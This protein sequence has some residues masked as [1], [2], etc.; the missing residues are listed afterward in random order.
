MQWLH[1]NKRDANGHYGDTW[2]SGGVQT[3]ILG[4]WN[5]NEQASVARAYLYTSTVPEPTGAALVV[6][7]AVM[8]LRRRVGIRLRIG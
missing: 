1:D 6:G 8:L 4:S 3:S 5:L 7:A 2:G